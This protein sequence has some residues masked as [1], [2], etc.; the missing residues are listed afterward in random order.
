MCT[1]KQDGSANLATVSSWTYLSFN[2]NMIAYAMAK[3]SYSRERVR[4]NQK[5]IVTIPGVGIADAVMGCG[6][7]TGRNIHRRGACGHKPFRRILTGLSALLMGIWSA[8][9]LLTACT[10]TTRH[11]VPARSPHNSGC[12]AITRGAGK[13]AATW[14]RWR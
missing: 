2:S 4:N 9:R 7:T 14:T 6:S 13:P 8:G 1:Q 12:E 10:R 11:G 5:V 3:T